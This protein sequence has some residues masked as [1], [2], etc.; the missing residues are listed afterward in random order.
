MHFTRDVAVFAATV[1]A[2]VAQLTSTVSQ[3]LSDSDYGCNTP[4]VVQ[5]GWATVYAEITD[6]EAIITTNQDLIANAESCACEKNYELRVILNNSATSLYQDPAPY[7][8]SAEW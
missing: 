7:R 5:D 3:T 4:V 6:R 8:I 1:S 2:A